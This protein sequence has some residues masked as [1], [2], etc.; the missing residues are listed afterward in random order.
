MT[1]LEEL[2][3]EIEIIKERNQRVE[4]DKAWETSLTRK[5]VVLLFT[6]IVVLIFF[7]AVHLSHPYTNAIVPTLGFA[8]STSTLPIV[9]RWW[10]KRH[11]GLA[12]S[13]T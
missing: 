6:Y 13:L 11:T 2:T 7:L 5:I 4:A 3:K 1:P 8:L 9:K 10:L 12:K